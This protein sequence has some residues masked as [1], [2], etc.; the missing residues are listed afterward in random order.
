[1][2]LKHTFKK[3]I[4]LKGT[5]LATVEEEKRRG[6]EGGGKREDDDK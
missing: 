1:M 3:T 6:G 4:L 2:P 5:C